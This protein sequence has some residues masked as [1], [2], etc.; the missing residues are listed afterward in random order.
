MAFIKS[1]LSSR[2]FLWAILA[3]PS[4]GFV[5]GL[6][7]ETMSVHKL[8]HP[9][10]EFSA[11]FM[12]IAMAATPLRL[13]FNGQRWTMWLVRNRRYFGVAAFLY[14]LF[15][16]IL[17]V[18]DTGS[19]QGMLDE[20]LK[21]GIWTGW[22]AFFIFIPL[23]LT[24]NDASVKAM[25]Q[26]WKPLQRWVYPAA[27]LTLLHWVFVENNVGPAMVHIVILGGLEAYRVWHQR[28]RKAKLVT[29]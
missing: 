4:L 6:V 11:R 26:K 10:G 29:S 18:V 28:F 7:N 22:L 8:L 24:S 16:T 1:T 3:L 15:H 19:V 13:M 12:I 9:T 23:A 25:R 5:M 20:A 27:V 14:A 17:Y 2:Y 21:L